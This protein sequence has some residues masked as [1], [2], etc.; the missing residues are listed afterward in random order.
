MPVRE[1]FL[2]AFGQW[3]FIGRRVVRD[4][5][6]GSEFPIPQECQKLANVDCTRKQVPVKIDAVIAGRFSHEVGSHFGKIGG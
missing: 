2:H 3:A 5:E 4:V 1:L 6:A